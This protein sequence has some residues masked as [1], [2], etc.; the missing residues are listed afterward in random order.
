MLPIGDQS[1]SVSINLKY[2]LKMI[3]KAHDKIIITF[4]LDEI[5]RGKVIGVKPEAD[6]SQTFM[7]EPLGVNFNHL[8][9]G[10]GVMRINSKDIDKSINIK[11]HKV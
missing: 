4:P 3:P 10:S 6:Q 7:I 2:R 5:K 11:I 8:K 9:N 1:L